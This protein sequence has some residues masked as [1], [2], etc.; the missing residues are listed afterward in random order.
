MPRKRLTEKHLTVQR[1]LSE[2]AVSDTV[3]FHS[4]VHKVT[5][6]KP[7]NENKLSYI[8][9]ALR[10]LNL[11]TQT[12][13]YLKSGICYQNAIREVVAQE[14]F[15][16]FI[17]NQTKT[18][19]IEP[20]K[21]SPSGNDF[22]VISKEV[23]GYRPLSDCSSKELIE[24]VNSGEYVGIGEILV[25]A[26][27]VDEYDLKFGNMCL[28][29]NNKIVKLDGDLAFSTLQAEE[30]TEIVTEEDISH[31]PCLRNHKAG[32]WLDYYQVHTQGDDE[33][34]QKNEDAPVAN[35]YA[36]SEVVRDE[37]NRALM[38]VLLMP[39]N[40]I[41]EFIESYVDHSMEKKF[42]IDEVMK[43]KRM[44]SHAAL[45]NES[46]RNY[47]VTSEASQQLDGFI[48]HISAFKTTGKNELQISADGL[49][50]RTQLARYQ[51]TIN[52]QHA[53]K[54]R[55]MFAKKRKYSEPENISDTKRNFV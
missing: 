34:I 48:E 30:E 29:E 40:V 2:S 9:L 33:Y 5:K 4:T 3:K 51:N 38:K 13:W 11:E 46:F 7:I 31:L 36:K 55:G 50:M 17:P 8:G 42:L 47:L 24:K 52:G 49:Y 19:L 28:D 21:L 23:P 54:Q 12:T 20:E 26:L 32:N 53:R 45:K 41:K 10:Y 15:R 16:L 1:K 25:I 37:I 27:L 39:Q 35:A 18:R 44:I 14:F 22:G 6:R 43:R